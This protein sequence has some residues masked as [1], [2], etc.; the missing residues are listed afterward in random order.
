MLQLPLLHLPDLVNREIINELTPIQQFLLSTC[1]VQMRRV[2]QA[3]INAVPIEHHVLCTPEK[4]VVT[5]FLDQHQKHTITVYSN[6]EFGNEIETNTC[7]IGNQ[8]MRNRVNESNVDLICADKEMGL[9][10]V[11]AKLWE[12]FDPVHISVSSHFVWLIRWIQNQRVQLQSV[13]TLYDAILDH[14]ECNYLL[15]ECNASRLYLSNQFPENF[16]NGNVEFR[17]RD[18]LE[19]TDGKW[20]SVQ[21]LLNTRASELKVNTS[22]FNQADYNSLLRFIVMIGAAPFRCLQ[23][24]LT[25]QVTTADLV[26]GIAVENG[27]GN[28]VFHSLDGSVRQPQPTDEIGLPDGSFVSIRGVDNIVMTFV[29]P[30][31]EVVHD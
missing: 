7:T 24:K 29:W 25:E 21:M 1:S 16:Q 12:L 22:N 20:M 5:L 30:N 9:R 2:L 4:S 31:L 15:R 10:A 17:E 14:D 19:I 13:Q 27:P 6:E 18:V 26:R 3:F 23:L 8:E 11:L 28:R